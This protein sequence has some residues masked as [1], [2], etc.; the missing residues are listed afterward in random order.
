M[1]ERLDRGVRAISW[2]LGCAY[3]LGNA[4]FG[5]AE[6]DVTIA[7]EASAI[8]G[9]FRGVYVLWMRYASKSHRFHRLR[10]LI[11]RCRALAEHSHG[12]DAEF[13][14]TTFILRDELSNLALG[15][16]RT[17]MDAALQSLQAYSAE[18]RWDLANENFPIERYE[19][20][21]QDRREAIA[22]IDARHLGTATTGRV[23]KEL[24]VKELQMHK[25]AM[26]QERLGRMALASL[27]T[28]SMA[29]VVFAGGDLIAS[30]VATIMDNFD[31]TEFLLPVVGVL[32][33][34]AYAW[35]L[36]RGNPALFTRKRRARSQGQEADLEQED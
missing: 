30:F 9:L 28:A 18:G 34:A 33:G 11:A 2:L 22:T 26:A 10:D 12:E 5:S 29:I 21:K 6:L 7:I 24:L 16:P 14:V 3:V 13:G 25:R 4:W 23:A 1:D 36:R 8:I 20:T 17:G 27:A 32:T 31:V 35:A 19:Y 15:L